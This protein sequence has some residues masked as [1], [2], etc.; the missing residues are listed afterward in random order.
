MTK[1]PVGWVALCILTA[2]AAPVRAQDASG[3]FEAYEDGYPPEGNQLELGVFGGV[4]I[5]DSKQNLR[6]ERFRQQKFRVTPEIGARLGYYPLSFLGIEGEAAGGTSKV[7]S[8]GARAMFFA[9]RGQCKKVPLTLR[10]S[11][12]DRE[13]ERSSAWTRSLRKAA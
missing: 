7:K 1:K 10:S 9:G 12:S 2:A 6:D 5:P 8:D 3:H 13:R 4:L 11:G